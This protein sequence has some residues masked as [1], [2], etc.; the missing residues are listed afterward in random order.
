MKLVNHL[1][2]ILLLF[3]VFRGCKSLFGNRLIVPENQA[4]NLL[5]ADPAFFVLILDQPPLPTAWHVLLVAKVSMEDHSSVEVLVFDEVIHKGV[6]TLSLH[7][8]SDFD[9]LSCEG[10]L[11]KKLLALIDLPYQSLSPLRLRK[12][13]DYLS[14]VELDVWLMGCAAYSLS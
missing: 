8:L 12:S 3:R 1:T 13:F 7:V 14:D 5:V 2:H 10:V 9:G 6:N 11:A 4:V